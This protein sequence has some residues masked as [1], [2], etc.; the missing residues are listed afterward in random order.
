MAIMKDFSSGI[1]VHE[2]FAIKRGI[3]VKK[4]NAELF[5]VSDVQHLLRRIKRTYHRMKLVFLRTFRT[6]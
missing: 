5:S 6:E 4:Y 3:I 2:I 1:V